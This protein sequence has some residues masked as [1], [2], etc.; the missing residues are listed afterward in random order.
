MFAKTPS[1]AMEDSVVMYDSMGE[2]PRKFSMQENTK[3]ANSTPKL[4]MVEEGKRDR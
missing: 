1:L 3:A 2:D 4:R